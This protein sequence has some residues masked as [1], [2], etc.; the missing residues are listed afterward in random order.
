MSLSSGSWDVRSLPRPGQPALGGRLGAGAP[1]SGA[2]ALCTLADE[3]D[4][5]R[6]RGEPEF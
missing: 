4:Q 1:R 3:V 5:R 6:V 2:G